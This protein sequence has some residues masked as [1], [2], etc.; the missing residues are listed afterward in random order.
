M[1]YK[2][3][4]RWLHTEKISNILKYSFRLKNYKRILG[5]YS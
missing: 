4:F 1:N 2:M 5:E 3:E